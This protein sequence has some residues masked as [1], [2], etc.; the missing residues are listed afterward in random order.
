MNARLT[1]TITLLS[2]VLMVLSIACENTPASPAPTQTD[3]APTQTNPGPTPTDPAPTQTNPAP[4]Q[5]N[6]GPTPTDPAPTPTNPAP[7]PTD[8]APTPTIPASTPTNPTSPAPDTPRE[9]GGNDDGLEQAKAELD[10]HRALWEASRAEDYSFVLTP[11]C[12]CP[13]DLLD[14]VRISVVD[15]IV[16]SV[17]YVES[18]KAPEHDG[19][20]RY[21]T[22]DDLF[23]TIQEGID[24]EAAQVTVSYDP[25]IGYPTDANI[26]YDA[27]RAD[28]E[29][30][31]TVSG[32]SPDGGGDGD[33][34]KQAQAELDKHRALWEASRAEDYSFVLTPICFCPQDLLDPVRISVVDGIVASVTYVES[35]KAPEHD[36]FGRYATIDDLFDTIQEGID[37]E[38]TQVTVSYDPVIGYPTDASIDYDSRMADEEY[39]FTVSGYSPG[40]G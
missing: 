12:F 20:G 34:L 6:P 14:P 31:F 28:E 17:T 19:Y 23:D 24:R 25:V 18:D 16:A 39:R 38:A 9:G 37:R 8:P 26:D 29:Y 21:V 7:T 15:G 3:P 1:A 13:Q 5:T 33:A 2:V 11:I 4:T 32:Y 22:I 30:R 36:G 40:E 10:K 35:D 27:R